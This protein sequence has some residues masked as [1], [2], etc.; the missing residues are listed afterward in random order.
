MTRLERQ[1]HL[2]NCLFDDVKG[3]LTERGIAV[4]RTCLTALTSPRRSSSSYQDERFAL[5]YGISISQ[6]QWWKKWHWRRV[7]EM[8]PKLWLRVLRRGGSDHV[9]YCMMP[10]KR[11][12]FFWIVKHSVLF[13]EGVFS[14]CS[15]FELVL[16][17]LS[18]NDR[19]EMISS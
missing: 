18:F 9:L 17:I 11:N 6:D 8:F 13:V 5:R 3:L 10:I 7:P 14:D 15:K 12:L 1:V 16:I 4:L 19:E 2:G